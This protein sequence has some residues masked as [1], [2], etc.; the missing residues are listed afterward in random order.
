MNEFPS[1]KIA[2]VGNGGC[3]IGRGAGPEIDAHPSVFR[4][5]NFQL[6]GHEPDAGTKTTGWV[7]TFLWDILARDI[8]GLAGIYCPA[9]LDDLDW[10]LNGNSHE[11]CKGLYF[12]LIAE[13]GKQTTFMP[14]AIFEELYGMVE[15]HASAGL[16]FLFW[17]WRAGRMKDVDLYGF[18]FF[19]PVDQHH[20][21]ED[22]TRPLDH[23]GL[24]EK[25]LIK[26]M[27]AC[28]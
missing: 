7:T 19:D 27:Q 25:L 5:N 23:R 14:R 2:V 13:Y 8:S 3:L 1:G 21:Y 15:H 4:F 26:G 16:G 11:Y 12:L 24:L 17:L 28:P 18:S 9:P 10:R 20:Y 6:A 22:K